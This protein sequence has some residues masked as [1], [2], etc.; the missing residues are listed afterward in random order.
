[1]IGRTLALARALAEAGAPVSPAELA[2]A[3]GALGALGEHLERGSVRAALG[4]T[5]AKSPEAQRLFARLFDLFFPA[6]FARER[7]R[8]D[9]ELSDEALREEVRKAIATGDDERLGALAALAVERFANL[10]GSRAAAGVYHSYRTARGLHLEQLRDQLLAGMR[11]TAPEELGW[12][13]R[14]REREAR[15]RLAA[16]TRRIDDEVLTRLAEDRNP[17]EVARSLGLRVAADVD[18]MHASREE[19]A[20]IRDAVRPLAAKLVARL[21]RRHA[22]ERGP[23]DL[24]RTMR[25]SL[26]TGGVPLDPAVRRRRPF[27]PDVVVLTDI[28][29]SVAAFARFTLQLLW[30]L[31]SEL[32]KLRSFAFIDAVDEVTPW[33]QGSWNLDA[34]LRDVGQHARVVGRVGH[35]DYGAVFEQ[36][37]RQH[38]EAL[39]PRT[40]LIILGDARTNYHDPG[41]RAFRELACRARSTHW[42]NPEPA[43]YWDTGDSVI[44]AYAPWC[45]S[46]V[47]CRT[48]AQL[49]RFVDEVLGRAS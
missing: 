4:A 35:S 27:R 25:R 44:G 37:A 47:E 10:G 38:L 8:A 34:A 36:F 42:L 14:E 15:R 5:L 39:G 30:A 20:E 33:V 18:I 7:S 22:R 31:G 2:D 45:T 6:G 12:R 3:L 19:L 41:V 29:G 24:R 46:V 48:L 9:E 43:R 21:E 13:E 23:F 1:V 16:L 40:T 32:R 28:S 26:Q 49:E 11:E 17:S